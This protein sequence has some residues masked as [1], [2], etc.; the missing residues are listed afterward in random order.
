M[1]D[2]E[3]M[4]IFNPYV[5]MALG[6]LAGNSGVNKSQAF[7]NAMQGGLGAV[8]QAQDLQRKQVM[9]RRQGKLDQM[10]L[11]EY[12]RMRV[13]VQ[14][15]RDWAKKQYEADPKGPMAAT[16]K[17]IADSEDP[18]VAMKMG[19]LQA[20][21]AGLAERGRYNDILDRHYMNP[22]Q[23][24]GNLNDTE[25]FM[26]DSEKYKQKKQIESEATNRPKNDPVLV[27]PP[28][29]FL[30]AAEEW[31]SGL[32]GDEV[33]PW[34]TGDYKLG[35]DKKKSIMMEAW[36]IIR[37]SPK[38]ISFDEAMKKALDAFRLGSSNVTRGTP[39]A[40]GWTVRQ[41]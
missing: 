20:E 7:S 38:E 8:T 4:K 36:N 2:Y 39:V 37:R 25:L 10:K 24:T 18:M 32:P 6:I 35:Q 33:G 40:D 13:G 14:Q 26:I 15:T 19:A 12:D 1:D 23:S 22:K 27:A 21:M 28:K 31:L 17:G 3:Q 30:T 16:Y 41:K 5:Q 29:D 34:N 11:D 9:D